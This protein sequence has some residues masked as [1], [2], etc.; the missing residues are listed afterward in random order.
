MELEIK[1]LQTLNARLRSESES[2]TAALDIARDR[3]FELSNELG[4]AKRQVE[5]LEQSLSAAAADD[6]EKKKAGM[7]ADM[8]ARID[9]VSARTLGSESS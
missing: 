7:L 3:E 4:L 5:T 9:T 6:R 8:M 2:T 1:D